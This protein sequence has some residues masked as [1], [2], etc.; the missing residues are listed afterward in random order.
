MVLALGYFIWTGSISTI[1]PLFGV[2]NQLL[3]VGGLAV[4]RRSSST[5]GAQKYAWVTFLPLCFLAVTTLTAG[6]LNIR[7]NYWPMAIGPNPALHVQGYVNTICTVIMMV[8]AVIILGATAHR[9]LGVLRG[10]L[11]RL[12]LA[13]SEA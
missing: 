12:S 7:D 6:Y 3:A 4:A 8:C 10:R 1:W 9:S 5:W 11:P 2:A 13:E